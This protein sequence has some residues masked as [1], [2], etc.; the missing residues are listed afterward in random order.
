M[1]FLLGLLGNR[2]VQYGL[3]AAAILFAWRIWSN[4]IYDQ[5]VE[6]GRITA[7]KEIEAAKQKEWVAKEEEIKAQF[8]AVEADRRAVD[9]ARSELARTRA[10]LT[11]TLTKTLAE[12]QGRET[13]T[14]AAVSAVPVAELDNALRA[15]SAELAA[16]SAPKP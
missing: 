9:A 15:V 3:I 10:N 1:T 14:G 5:G 13:A 7:T 16:V 12:I 4:R 6:A 8:Q 11:N 2:W